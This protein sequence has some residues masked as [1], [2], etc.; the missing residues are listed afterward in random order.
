[1]FRDRAFQIKMVKD[2]NASDT[3]PEAVTYDP[4]YISDVANEFVTKTAVTIAMVYA[5]MKLVD[6]ISKVIVIAAK[7]KIK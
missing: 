1:M 6:T 4:E 2:K 7:A 3:L 5:G